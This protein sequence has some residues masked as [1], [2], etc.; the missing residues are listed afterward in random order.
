MSERSLSAKA[1]MLVL[2]LQTIF[3]ASSLI[4]G[5]IAEMLDFATITPFSHVLLFAVFAIGL[6]YN[7]EKSHHVQSTLGT[8]IIWNG[9]TLVT[10]WYLIINYSYSPT[11]FYYSLA[12]VIPI[13]AATM[14]LKMVDFDPAYDIHDE[15]EDFIQD[16]LDQPSLETGLDLILVGAKDLYNEEAYEEFLEYLREGDSE[17]SRLFRSRELDMDT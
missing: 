4:L 13:L 8:L 3:F 5:L 14:Y 6:L 17:V 7:R 9:V 10:W 15:F 1:L 2:I 11:G 12:L 16:A